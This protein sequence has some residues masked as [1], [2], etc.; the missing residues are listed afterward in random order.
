MGRVL[1][2]PVEGKCPTIAGEVAV[3]AIAAALAREAG[4]PASGET[5]L[6]PDVCRWPAPPAVVPSW[7]RTARAPSTDSDAQEYLE[8][9]RALGYL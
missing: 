9:L 5:P 2:R 6:P 7:G 8:S 3:G 1:L 4:L